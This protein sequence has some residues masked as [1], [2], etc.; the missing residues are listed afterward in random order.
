MFCGLGSSGQFVATGVLQTSHLK[1]QQ[2]PWDVSVTSD[3]VVL[4][5]RNCTGLGLEGKI[6]TFWWEERP[7]V[8]CAKWD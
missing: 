8:T 4:S 3:C 2:M 6:P 7:M 5:A 1:P